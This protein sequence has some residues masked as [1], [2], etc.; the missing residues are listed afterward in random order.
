M[1]I[2]LKFLLKKLR[3]SGLTLFSKCCAAALKQIW[4]QEA[5]TDALRTY[6][7]ILSLH[8]VDDQVE[9]RFPG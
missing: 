4:R 9:F 6:S 7:L 3:A 2:A 8:S 1:A 5:R